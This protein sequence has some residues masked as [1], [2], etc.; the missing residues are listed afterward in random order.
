MNSLA[1][2]AFKAVFAGGQAWAAWTGIVLKGGDVRA[3]DLL[4]AS[5]ASL[6]ACSV[7]G[8]QSRSY[9]RIVRCP[10]FPQKAVHITPLGVFCLLVCASQAISLVNLTPTCSSSAALAQPCLIAVIYFAFVYRVSQR[11]EHARIPGAFLR[12]RCVSALPGVCGS[13]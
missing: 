9:R 10:V 12:A 3:A 11:G 6:F 13:A 8:S 4:D 2:S 1:G 7:G 5:L